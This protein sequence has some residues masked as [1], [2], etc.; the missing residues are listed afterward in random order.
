VKLIVLANG[1]A[2]QVATWMVSLYATGVIIGRAIFGVALDRIGAHLV[3]LFAL[4]LPAV[5]F[6]ILASSLNSVWLLA[7]GILVIGA[8]QGAEGDVGGYMISRHFELE[9]LQFDIRLHEG[10]S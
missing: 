3:A 8:A 4:S 6:I 5:G 10:R 1:V 9:N 2:D 7:L